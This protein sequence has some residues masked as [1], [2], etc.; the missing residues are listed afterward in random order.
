MWHPLEQGFAHHAGSFGNPVASSE[1]GAV[2]DYFS[3]EKI[4]DGHAATSDVY[5]T[6]D[7]VN[8]AIS[9]MSTLAEPWF[10]YVAFNAPHDPFHLPPAHL[11]SF[12][13]DETSPPPLRYAAMVE[14]LDTELGRLLASVAPDVLER[15]TVIFLGDNG[16][17]RRVVLSPRDRERSKTTVFEGGVNVPL[18]VV[19][20]T[21]ARPGSEAHA[22]VHAVDVFATVAEIAGVRVS[23]PGLVESPALDIDELDIDGLSLLPILADPDHPSMRRYSWSERYIQ[24][25]FGDHDL[26]SRTIR[27]D[28]WKLVRHL[29]GRVELYDTT[30]GTWDEG[31]D[32]MPDLDATQQRA[33]ERLDG[34]HD[35]M[36]E[37]IAPE[38]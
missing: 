30:L 29:G 4:V 18:L 27:D 7:T 17:H 34:A 36:L 33:R 5:M 15:T 13:L 21:V 2:T 11:H 24:N 22:F 16:T 26:D 31:P 8:D 25:G 20:P 12:D 37:R 1:P 14:S 35:R 28:R 10:L 32:L 6:T 38:P 23:P 3:W 9:E 19:G